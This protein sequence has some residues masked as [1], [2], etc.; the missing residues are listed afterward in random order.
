MEDHNISNQIPIPA[1]TPF[2]IFRRR[3]GEISCHDE[4]K[5]IKH[6]DL[7]TMFRQCDYIFELRGVIFC[8]FF[9]LLF[10]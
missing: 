10:A 6:V 1:I 2:P 4:D 8:L 9:L 3:V 7:H 5:L